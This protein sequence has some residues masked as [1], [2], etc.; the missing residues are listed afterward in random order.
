MQLHADVPKLEDTPT[1]A[2][3]PLCSPTVVPAIWAAVESKLPQAISIVFNVDERI[4]KA[5]KA[6]AHR[7][8]EYRSDKAAAGY[9][10]TC[11]WYRTDLENSINSDSY[12]AVHLMCLP[13]SRVQPV[14]QTWGADATATEITSGLWNI[15]SERPSGD[16]Q[17]VMEINPNTNSHHRWFP[18][19][20]LS[21]SY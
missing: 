8:N 21:V 6:W 9:F 1:P 13:T 7:Y 14:S 11:E 15:H 20:L 17:L 18:R 4:A 5:T 16:Q 2:P 10:S 19:N 3:P 12:V